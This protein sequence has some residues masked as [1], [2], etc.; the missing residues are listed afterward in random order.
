[1]K[2]LLIFLK[3]LYMVK[4]VAKFF[5]YRRL[6]LISIDEM[7]YLPSLVEA[8]ET[9]VEP[10]IMDYGKVIEAAKSKPILRER[11]SPAIK[12]ERGVGIGGGWDGI[13]KYNMHAQY[14]HIHPYTY[15]VL[16]RLCPS[17]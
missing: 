15:S 13:V 16:R 12:L 14:M 2:N 1:M 8:L 17:T 5:E 6:G 4:A 11:V 10:Y 7:W 3:A 9:Y